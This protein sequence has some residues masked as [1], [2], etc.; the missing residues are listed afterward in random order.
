MRAFIYGIK[1][2]SQSFYNEFFFLKAS[3]EEFEVDLRYMALSGINSKL[4]KKRV[5][6]SLG[7]FPTISFIRFFFFREEK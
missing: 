6:C 3:F 7:S 2:H 1:R 4:G 5:M